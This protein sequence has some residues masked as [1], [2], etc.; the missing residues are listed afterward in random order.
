[1]T[2]A[3][4]S[5]D[6]AMVRETLTVLLDQAMPCCAAVDYRI[7]GTAAA[8]LH[9]VSLPASD[10]DI[11]M[12]R[13]QDVDAFSAALKNIPCLHEP[14]LLPGDIQYFARYEVGGI[15]V[16]FSTVEIASDSDA[17]EC[18]G[19][20]PWKYFSLIQV[21]RHHVPVVALE[22]RLITEVCRDRPDR[23]EPLI[24]FLLLH[25]CDAG[26]IGRGL[27]RAGALATLREL[28]LARL[29]GVPPKKARGGDCVPP[30][31][32]MRPG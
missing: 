7:V 2:R 14:E 17:V 24:E 3:D 25:G 28:V 27:E 22:L 4:M 29:A 5:L 10:I 6:R 21:G 19:D 12:R 16:E 8:L 13:R 18:S 30:G 32:A 1:M 15:Q 20:G 11:L 9:G 31:P 26:L 23:Y